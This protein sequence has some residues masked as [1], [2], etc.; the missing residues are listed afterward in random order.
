MKCKTEF[1]YLV[2]VA[3]DHIATLP[4]SS[5]VVVAREAQ[6]CIQNIAA[7]LQAADA[8][9]AEAV[10]AAPVTPAAPSKAAEN[11]ADGS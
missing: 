2:Q 9:P 8:P 5:K 10:P 6:A 4:P 1:E 7:V 11:A 3:N